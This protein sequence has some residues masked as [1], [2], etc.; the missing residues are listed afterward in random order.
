MNSF[1]F[2]SYDLLLACFLVLN[3]P[4]RI[5]SLVDQKDDP[6]NNEEKEWGEQPNEKR[7]YKYRK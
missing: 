3:S 1:W 4:T 5:N 2:E 7:Q 6:K